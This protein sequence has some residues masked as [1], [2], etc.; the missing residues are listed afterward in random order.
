MSPALSKRSSRRFA[1]AR[2]TMSFSAPSTR[3]FRSRGSGG[4]RERIW[5]KRLDHRG[6]LEGHLSGQ[7][8]VERDAQRVDVRPRV[9]LPE[10]RLDLLGRGVLG[11]AAE[12]PDARDRERFLGERQPEIEEE[13]ATVGRDAHVRG[14]HVAVDDAGR[15]RALERPRDVPR[16]TDRGGDV[17]RRAGAP[18]RLEHLVEARTL[19]DFH[20]EVGDAL[21]L[22]GVVDADDVL[23]PELR[24]PL[25]LALEAP[26]RRRRERELRAN[27][28]ERDAALEEPVLGEV[29]ATHAAL[30]HA[31]E[32]LVGA[33]LLEVRARR[34]SGPDRTRPR[35]SAARSPA[36]RRS[37][38][39][40]RRS[41][42]DVRILAEQ[43]PLHDAIDRIVVDGFGVGHPTSL[44]I[45]DRADRV[46]AAREDDHDRRRSRSIRAGW[47][48]RR[49]RAVARRDMTEGR[50]PR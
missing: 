7:A 49:V 22:A 45:R 13:R 8:L 1:I 39:A 15:V 32:D 47:A 2:F 4:S 6:A 3:A 50:R 40:R 29:H 37:C 9:D 11:R 44:S 34:R 21:V 27:D 10:S 20:G 36:V 5:W 26:A 12:V 46:F 14:L 25:R 18:R 42:L 43:D 28:L 17:H 16:V 31:R 19:D 48:I 24:D 38:P 33:E 35:S 30:A 23:V 41:G